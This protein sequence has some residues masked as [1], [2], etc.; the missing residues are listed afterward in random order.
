MTRILPDTNAAQPPAGLPAEN[1]KK[2]FTSKQRRAD[3]GAYHR[4]MDLY[5]GD[6]KGHD[7][8]VLARRPNL[9]NRASTLSR[10]ETV[11]PHLETSLAE[12]KKKLAYAQAQLDVAVGMGVDDPVA[13]RRVLAAQSDVKAAEGQLATLDG[14]ISKAGLPDGKVAPQL[15]RLRRALD[16][17]Q[18]NMMKDATPDNTRRAFAAR[19]ALVQY[20]SEE[21]EGF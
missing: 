16:L 15:T 2:A 20:I 18:K 4:S 13:T 3:D 14:H 11:K 21:N 8:A 19:N 7:K 5:G 12:K 10:L 1:T 9:P 17:A 6:F